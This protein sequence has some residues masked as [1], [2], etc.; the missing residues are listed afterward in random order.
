M[1]SAE[2]SIVDIWKHDG[3]LR[4]ETLRTWQPKG[5]KIDGN[6]SEERHFSEWRLELGNIKLSSIQGQEVSP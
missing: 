1:V 2:G 5:L 4:R 6:R 3:W